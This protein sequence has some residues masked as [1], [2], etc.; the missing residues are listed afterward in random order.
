M[1]HICIIVADGARARFMTLEV[2][3]DTALDGGARLVERDDLVNPEADVA[4]RDLYSDRR[5]RGHS[6]KDGAAHALDD[7]RGQHQHEHE[8]RYARRLVERAEAFVSQQQA[9]HLVLVAEP[10]LLGTFRQQNDSRALA[11]LD[12]VEISENLSR[13]T[14]EDIQAIL[15]SKGLVPGAEAPTASV[16]RPRGQHPSNP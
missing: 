7:H 3:A 9:R 2:P 5:G 1:T 10:R 8:R 6:S 11:A 12:L 4:D 15:A 13:R 16:F 14:L